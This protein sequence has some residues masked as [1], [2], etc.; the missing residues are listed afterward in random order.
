MSS[1]EMK[2]PSGGSVTIT[3]E[4]RTANEQYILPAGEGTVL[5]A[6]QTQPTS[7]NTTTTKIPV[8]VDGVTYYILATTVGG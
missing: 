8:V 7:D 4:D 6:D 1:I 3:P 2:T 5:V